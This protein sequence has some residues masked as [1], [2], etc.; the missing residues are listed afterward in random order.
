MILITGG[1]GMVGSHIR[2]E[3][4]KKN[5]PMRAIYRRD[6]SLNHIKSFFKKSFPRNTNLFKS[7]EWI[8]TDLNDLVG[9][10]MAFKGVE[11]VYHYAAKVSLV[12]FHE[13][14]LLSNL[15]N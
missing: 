10:D 5:E 6:E 13:K 7:I 12:Q 14:K 11:Y 15:L 8:K 9:L 2:L 1:T 3:Y 4:V